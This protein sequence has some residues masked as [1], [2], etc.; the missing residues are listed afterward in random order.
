M[1]EHKSFLH[2]IEH[3]NA[4]KQDMVVLTI[5]E[6]KGS[7]YRKPG[8]TMLVNSN[9]E[10][11]GVL[12]GGCI[13]EAMIHCCDEVLKQHYGKLVTHDL[14]LPDDSKESWEV[15]V[16]CNGL[17]QVW[18]EPFYVDEAY[19][20]L[21]EAVTYAKEGIA[22]TLIRSTQKEK[23]GEYRFIDVLLDSDFAY[24]EED[25][26]ILQKIKPLY[27]V[28][29][30]GVGSAVQA[31]VD[32]A[33]ILGWEVTLGD[34]RKENLAEIKNTD[35]KHWFESGLDIQKVLVGQHFDAAVIMS[36]EFKNDSIYVKE[37]MQ[38]N[39]SYVGLL[40]SKKRTQKI[41]EIVQRNNVY[42]DDRFHAP[43]GLD[44]GA[45]TPQSIALAIC[46]EIEAKRSHKQ[47]S[48]LRG[49][50]ANK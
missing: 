29:I 35:H 16:G 34:T 30:L 10:S 45:Q 32:I 42:L 47:G 14:R 2:F 8:T 39:I 20:A 48:F 37:L 19:G 46:A 31:L 17:I 9:H 13:E 6:T 5:V 49:H 28:L 12:S 26:F 22:Q 27:K 3:C 7:T 25:H 24:N 1:F 44:I 21:G 11:V 15:G 41:I 33:N 18:L 40:G 36:H 23:N 38:S 43:V 50:D 4:T